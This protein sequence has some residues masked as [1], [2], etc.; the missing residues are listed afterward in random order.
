MF[1]S[2]DP[3]ANIRRMVHAPAHLM[4]SFSLL[5]PLDTHYRIATCAEVECKGYR[6]EMTVTFDLT[7]AQHVSDANWLRNHSGLRFTYF[8]LDN[9]RKVRFV[10]PAGQTCLESR[11]RPHRVPL[12]RDPFMVVRGG[13]VF[14]GNP[15]GMTHTH[16][17]PE[18]F[19]DE[20]ATDLDKLK[21]VQE[22][23]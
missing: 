2:G 8:M 1:S 18:S 17:S 5:Q 20:W 7:N 21:T 19:V 3:Y 4:K 14:R 15:T 12:E 22:R 23:G 6:S 10:I 11:L 9:E 13:D 16:T